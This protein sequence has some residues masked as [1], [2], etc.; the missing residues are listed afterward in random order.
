VRR[1]SRPDHVE[2]VRCRR[3][4]SNGPRDVQPEPPAAGLLDAHGSLV[5]VEAPL[6]QDEAVLE[7]VAVRRELERWVE[8]HLAVREVDPALSL[9]LADQRPQDAPMQP[10]MR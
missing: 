1:L 3:T 6:Q 4:Q 9:V 7:V 2:Q 5:L 8:S 10:L